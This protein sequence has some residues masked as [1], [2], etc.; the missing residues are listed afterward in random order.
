MCS[1]CSIVHPVATAICP[2]RGALPSSPST[3]GSQFTGPKPRHNGK[4]I[5]VT[6]ATQAAPTVPALGCTSASGAAASTPPR[7]APRVP[8]P[9]ASKSISRVLCTPVL[10]D[11]LDALL[12]S[13]PDA[14]FRSYVCSGMRDG[15]SIDSDSSLSCFSTS[16]NHPSALLKKILCQP[17][18]CLAVMCVKLRAHS[19]PLHSVTC[20]CLAWGQSQNTMGNCGYPCLFIPT[21]PQRK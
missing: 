17:I 8:R 7:P 5:C 14:T 16:P 9:L 19:H 12:A 1:R 15:F 4:I 11:R 3:A 6:I 18:C 20:R 21:W 13:H 10:V 2:F